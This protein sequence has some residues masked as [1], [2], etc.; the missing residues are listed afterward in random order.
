MGK[1]FRIRQ[2]FLFIFCHTFQRWNNFG[3][4]NTIIFFK[5]N[6]NKFILNHI[7]PNT[8]NLDSLLYE[9]YLTR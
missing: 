4:Q 6:F 5:I 2:N 9:T 1:K 7:L 3:K 8:Q